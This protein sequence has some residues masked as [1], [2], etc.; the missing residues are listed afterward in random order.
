MSF[1]LDDLSSLAAYA[2]VV[3]AKS[4]TAAAA[5]LRLSK[6]V[7]SS[8]LSDLEARLGVRLLHRTTRRL[9]L[10]TEGALLYERCSRI[11]RAA[12]EAAEVIADVGTHPQGLLRITAPIGFGLLQLAEL[13]PDFSQ[14][15]PDVRL[16]ISLSDR[17]LDIAAEG[18]DVAVRV[19]SRLRESNLVARRLGV[20]RLILCAAPSYLERRATPRTPQDLT[21]HNC[22]QLFAVRQSYEWSFLAPGGPVVVPVR[23]N[24]NLDN[25][26]ALRT[27]LLGGHGIAVMPQSVVAADLKRG[28]LVH[29]LPHHPMQEMGVYVVHA[30]GRHVPAKVRVF[31]DFLL[32]RLRLGKKGKPRR[33]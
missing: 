15:Y 22:L 26:V 33:G 6:S 8:R 20:D 25:V 10:T 31:I 1:S 29:L 23:G 3:E 16:D 24:L 11:L 32:E 19:A 17:I 27:A 9:S 21:E 2:H 4:F 30:H 28:R 18:F 13:L 7:V 14:R 5:R 12:E